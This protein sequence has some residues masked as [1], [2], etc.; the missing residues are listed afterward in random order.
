MSGQNDTAQ[1]NDETL[2]K[3]DYM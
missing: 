1:K 3:H 2:L